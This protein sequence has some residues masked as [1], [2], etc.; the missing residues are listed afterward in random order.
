MMPRTVRSPE[1]ATRHR[2]PPMALAPAFEF[3]RE[4]ALAWASLDSARVPAN[5]E[6]RVTV[7]R[8]FALRTAG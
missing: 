5:C 1:A 3:E 2:V 7:L 8:P 4:L 6:R